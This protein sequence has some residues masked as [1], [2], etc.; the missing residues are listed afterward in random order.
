MAVPGM[1]MIPGPIGEMGRMWPGGMYGTFAPPGSS[2]YRPEITQY[3]VIPYGYVQQGP[4][5]PA[6]MQH[7]PPMKA[8][9]NV[10]V[11][12]TLS[13]YFSNYL[14]IF[15]SIHLPIFISLSLAQ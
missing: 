15:L 1:Q 3:G 13:L 12:F 9:A 5:H 11:R 8:P 14:F 6:M 2:A 7:M 4:L 10:G